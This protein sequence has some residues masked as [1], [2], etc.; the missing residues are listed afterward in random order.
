MSEDTPKIHTLC[1]VCGSPFV[2]SLYALSNTCESCTKLSPEEVEKLRRAAEIIAEAEREAE[3]DPEPEPATDKRYFEFLET[4]KSFWK[5]QIEVAT[6]LDL[7]RLVEYIKR[8]MKEFCIECGVDILI[9]RRRTVRLKI[10]DKHKLEYD[11]WKKR[12]SDTIYRIEHG[13]SGSTTEYI[14]PAPFN[15][16]TMGILMG[17]PR[18]PARKRGAGALQP[19]KKHI[20]KSSVDRSHQQYVP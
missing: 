16:N 6:E 8:D 9:R 19:K 18:K 5:R 13:Q 4:R 11:N 10:C 20:R 12:K 1:D 2:D 7:L 3:K 17:N 15:P 14:I